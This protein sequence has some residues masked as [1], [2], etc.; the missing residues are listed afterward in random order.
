MLYSTHFRLLSRDFLGLVRDLCIVSEWKRVA[1]E[2]LEAVETLVVDFEKLNCAI[3]LTSF[4]RFSEKFVMICICSSSKA[5][6]SES[7]FSEISYS[8]MQAE[9]LNVILADWR[10]TFC[11]GN[12]LPRD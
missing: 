9:M 7:K 5:E 10:Q 6:H 11:H 1:S 2:R 8:N 12:A 3:Q 4:I